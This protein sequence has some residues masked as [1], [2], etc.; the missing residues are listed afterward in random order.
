MTL[1]EALQNR[2]CKVWEARWDSQEVGTWKCVDY[3][4]PRGVDNEREAKGSDDKIK[5]LSIVQSMELWW[6]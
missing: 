4:G 1:I 3:Q 6:V 5:L 2:E